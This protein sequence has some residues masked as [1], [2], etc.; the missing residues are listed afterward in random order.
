MKIDQN[1]INYALFLSIDN[2]RLEEHTEECV[3]L[4]LRYVLALW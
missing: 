3:L 2:F 1:Q 4:L